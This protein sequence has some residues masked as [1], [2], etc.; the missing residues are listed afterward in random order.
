MVDVHSRIRI[1]STDGTFQDEV[2]LPRAGTVNT[3]AVWWGHAAM[4]PMLMAG[5]GDFTFTFASYEVSPSVYRYDLENRKLELIAP[6]RTEHR[7][8][9]TRQVH[10]AGTDGARVSS[11]VVHRRDLD[12]KR[13]HPAL[14]YG[15]GGWN[16]AFVQTYI[17][18]LAAI[19]EAGGILA[20]PNL[21]GG[22]EYGWDWW[23]QGRLEHKQQTY[24]DLYS[25][26][27][28]LIG[29]GLT[30]SSMLAIA[31]ASNGGL[32]TAVA[33]TQRPELFKAVVSLV[34]VI[35][36]MRFTRDSF[37]EQM[38]EEYGD[39]RKA[40]DAPYIHAYSP[41]HN[42]REG[43]AYPATLV[44]CSENDIRCPPWNG[45]KM[46]ARMQ[47]ANASDTPILL[48]V[49][50]DSGH[51]AA[52]LGDAARTSDWLG[53]IMEQLDLAPPGPE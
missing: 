48:R 19:V 43:T 51:P 28:Y 26:A 4:E 44:V 27:E 34:P 38:I 3:N 18:A 31:G 22:G 45:R 16:I 35:D 5:T 39:P 37:G 11:W 30:S 23:Q 33:V 6:A 25:T 20:F 50:S 9:V 32:L 17:G 2:K 13:P 42:V 14:I 21:R 8:V 46:V 41:Y 49:W 36:A 53:F 10:F 12:L 47:H 1:F 24:D 29:E 52:L 7:D 40:G 15:Y